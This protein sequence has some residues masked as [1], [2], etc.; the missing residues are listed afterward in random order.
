MNSNDSDE[1]D[2][3]YCDYGTTE[4]V[5]RSDVITHIPTAFKSSV[6][7]AYLCQLH[8]ILPVGQNL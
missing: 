8:G 2:V 6:Q 7:T 1:V 3:L 4:F 5:A